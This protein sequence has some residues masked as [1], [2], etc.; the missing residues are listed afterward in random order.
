MK[1]VYA[2][3][4]DLL[5]AALDRNGLPATAAGLAMVVQL[6]DGARDTLIAREAKRFG[7]APSALSY[8][9]DNQEHGRSGLLLGVTGASDD[10]LSQHC[11]RLRQLIEQFS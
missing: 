1:R 11:A 6:P 3:R 9:Y 4:R 8:W 2:T 10:R 7:L 5:A